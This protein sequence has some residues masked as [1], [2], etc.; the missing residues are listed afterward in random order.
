M[1]PMQLRLSTPFLLFALLLVLATSG[2]AERFVR[3][4]VIK[5]TKMEADLVRT[6]K[7]FEVQPKT[8]EHPAIISVP[9]L[10]H[11]LN[12]IEVETPAKDGGFVRQPA[13]HPD[14]IQTTAEALAE[15]LA[16][17]D[18]NEEVGISAVRKE[19]RLGILHRKYLTSFLA[20]VE[21]DNLYID[22]DRIEWVIPRDLA[23]GKMPK[24]RHDR[25]PMKFR[26]VHGDHLYF[27]G[28]Q[29]LEIDW[30]N[31]A[32]SQPYRLQGSTEGAK[33]KR[34]ILLQVPV[35]QAERD[36]MNKASGSV[37][38]LSPEQLRALADLEEDR[39][40]GKITETTYQRARRQ[41][42]RER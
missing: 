4:N 7:G 13:F 18:P 3:H 9:R 8:F 24:P 34:E 26:A 41:L 2:C 42:L 27:A 12:A 25:P 16:Q 20:R 33:K 5:N 35:P 1:N 38:E 28:A 39:R 10:T 30:Q 14:I 11:I 36:E 19:R 15:S 37:D 23:G 29:T 40:A 31:D 21:N 17:A 32:F 22:L 6:V